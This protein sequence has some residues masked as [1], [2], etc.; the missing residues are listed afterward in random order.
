M[1]KKEII[2]FQKNIELDIITGCWTWKSFKDKDDYGRFYIEGKIKR[3]H[4]ISYEHWNGEIIK[5]LVIDH[6]CRNTSCVNPHHLEAVTIKE[7]TNRGR[8]H[9]REKT[10]CKNGHLFDE[11]NTYYRPN[12]GR[13]CRVCDREYKKEK[14]LKNG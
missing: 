13:N 14:R 7:N 10:Q 6:L 1:N 2:R 3:A 5:G 12:G 8:N 11:I 9:E 4:R